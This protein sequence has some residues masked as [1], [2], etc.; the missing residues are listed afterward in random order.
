MPANADLSASQYLGVEENSTGKAVVATT[1]G[2]AGVGILY[3]KPDAADR[4]A[5]VA[6]SGVAKGMAG[7]AI[8]PGAKVTVMANG[9]FQ[10]AGSTHHVWGK[11]RGSAA[12]A[13]GDIIEIDLDDTKPVLA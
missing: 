7:A 3:N 5:E 9:R 11:Y 13:N 10:T 4:A 12:C 2:Q 6:V 8:T 1:L